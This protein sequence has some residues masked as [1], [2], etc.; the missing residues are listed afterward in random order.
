[1]Q[2]NEAPE[3]VQVAFLP[4]ETSGYNLGPSL[5]E[6][7]QPL[8]WQQE[9]ESLGAAYSGGARLSKDDFVAAIVTDK[10]HEEL[11][12]SSRLWRQ[13]RLSTCH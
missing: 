11:A 13:V 2:G 12:Q 10:R 3:K 9:Q 7:Q 8:P 4:V 5:P 1:M 6:A